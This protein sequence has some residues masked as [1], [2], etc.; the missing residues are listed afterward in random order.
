MKGQAAIEQV[1]LH[2]RS[3]ECGLPDGDIAYQLRMCER[4]RRTGDRDGEIGIERQP[5]AVADDRLMH[6]GGASGQRHR[7]RPVEGLPDLEVVEVGSAG[8]AGMHCH[9]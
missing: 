8:L 6:R 2:P 5:K 4:R 9:G 1:G 7:R 3:G